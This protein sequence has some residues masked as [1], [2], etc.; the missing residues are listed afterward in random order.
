MIM[1]SAMQKTGNSK[2]RVPNN[3]PML[4]FDF[5]FQFLT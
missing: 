3:E 5:E 2:I 4:W 1:L